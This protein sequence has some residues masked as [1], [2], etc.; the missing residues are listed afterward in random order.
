MKLSECGDV[1]WQKTSVCKLGFDL[2]KRWFDNVGLIAQLKNGERATSRDMKERGQSNRG[3]KGDRS[4]EWDWLV[5][6]GVDCGV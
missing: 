1:A 5:W 4:E 6:C 2:I 3:I